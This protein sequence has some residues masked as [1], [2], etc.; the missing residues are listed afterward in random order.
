[1]PMNKGHEAMA[2]LT[3]IID[4]YATLPSTMAFMHPH[5]SGFLAAWHTDTPLHSNVDALNSLQLAFVE[6]KGYANLRCNHNPGCIK[7]HWRNKWISARTWHELFDGTSIDDGSTHDMPSYLAAACC[8]QF[9]VSRTQVLKRPLSD[10]EHFRQWIFDTNM[11]D[12]YSGRAFEYLWHIIFGMEAVQCV[13]LFASLPP[14][15]S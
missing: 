8:A 1:M 11:T 9:A 4:N 13:E 3:Y 10:Y 6:Q 5:R 14:S 2:Y 15:V 12:R 7:E